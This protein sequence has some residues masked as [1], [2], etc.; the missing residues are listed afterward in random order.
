MKKFN[1][2]KKATPQPKRS[3]YKVFAFTL[4]EVLITLTIIGIVAAFTIPTLM[5]N[6]T[7]RVFTSAQDVALKKITEA[8]NQMKTNDALSGYA[9]T[10]AFADEFLKYI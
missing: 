9:T 7:Q 1:P 4:A 5:A 2:T 8:T 10:D 3:K 6:V